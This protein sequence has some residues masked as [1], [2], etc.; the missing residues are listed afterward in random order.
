MI[1]LLYPRWYY[2]IPGWYYYIPGWTLANTNLCNVVMC[3]IINIKVFYYL[4]ESKSAEMR[5][6]KLRG[7]EMPR[8]TWFYLENIL[9]NQ[10]V[11]N[12]EIDKFVHIYL[13]FFCNPSKIFLDDLQS[14]GCDLLQ[15]S[16]HLFVLHETAIT[17]GP[18]SPRVRVD[19]VG[20]E[21]FI[22][23]RQQINK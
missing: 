1:I 20:E 16:V 4:N 17:R 7:F 14:L 11:H 10:E 19:D 3:T 12:I 2:Y 23:K 8:L 5:N 9:A 13:D 22:F 15:F 21:D 6:N 18:E